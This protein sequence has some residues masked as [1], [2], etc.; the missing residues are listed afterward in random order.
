MILLDL[1]VLHILY[2]CL[3]ELYIACGSLYVAEWKDQTT[4]E[5][6]A[7]TG[8]TLGDAETYCSSSLPDPT[9]DY[10][11]AA[12]SNDLLPEQLQNS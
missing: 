5:N 10:I 1:W 4:T 2:K 8:F 12:S 11:S 6:A 3:T 9:S 7:L